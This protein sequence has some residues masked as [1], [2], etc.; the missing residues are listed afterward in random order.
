MKGN[1]IF[2][3]TSILALIFIIVGGILT[4]VNTPNNESIAQNLSNMKVLVGF[5]LIILGVINTI[6]I[7]CVYVDYKKKFKKN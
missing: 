6:V 1:K 3:V 2:K 7:L 4:I 5:I